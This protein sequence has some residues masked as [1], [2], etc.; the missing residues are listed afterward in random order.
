VWSAANRDL[1]VIQAVALMDQAGVVLPQGEA[2]DLVSIKI[3]FAQRSGVDTEFHP[4]SN[5][6]SR[7]RL[8]Q[9]GP[10]NLGEVRL[11]D[12]VQ[13]A[14]ILQE[15]PGLNEN[16]IRVFQLRAILHEFFHALDFGDAVRATAGDQDA[17]IALQARHLSFSRNRPG[18]ARNEID[19]DLRTGL[20]LKRNGLVF[21]ELRQSLD[22]YRVFWESQGPLSEQAFASVLA[23]LNRTRYP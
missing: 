4:W 20:V 1:L 7:V 6:E 2:E 5:Q 22:G 19:T 11:G 23:A 13:A 14:R 21:P 15:C 17:A 3:P 10:R 12:N 16:R 18:Y 9:G 8:A